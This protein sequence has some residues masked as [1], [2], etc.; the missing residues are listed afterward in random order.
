MEMMLF[1]HLE[2][3]IHVAYAYA[4][5]T[6]FYVSQEARLWFPIEENY[7]VSM[8]VSTTGLVRQFGGFATKPDNTSSIPT[9]GSCCLTSTYT[10]WQA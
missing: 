8:T 1:G 5:Y 3:A 10:Q 4:I 6:P 9:P 2:R 7:T